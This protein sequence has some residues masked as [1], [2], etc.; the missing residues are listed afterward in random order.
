MSECVEAYVAVPDMPRREGFRSDQPLHPGRIRP[1][2]PARPR[3]HRIAV[4]DMAR[5]E[6]VLSGQPLRPGRIRP[7]YQIRPGNI[8]EGAA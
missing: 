6:G 5:W 8:A 3:D 2:Y 7:G 4:P 1:G